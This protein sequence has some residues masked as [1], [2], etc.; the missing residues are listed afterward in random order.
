MVERPTRH[1][2]EPARAFG[3]EPDAHDSAVVGVV[4]ATDETRRFGAV[5]QL[6]R[7]VVTQEKL[8]GDITDGRVVGSG[9]PSHREQQLMLHRRHPELRRLVLAPAQEPAQRRAEGQQALVVT[10]RRRRRAWHRYI[11]PRY[12]F[13]VNRREL[14]L[15]GLAVLLGLAGG[16]AAWVLVHLIGLLTNLALLHR[17]A[18]KMPT[19][20]HYHPDWSLVVV[21]VAGAGVV[22]LLARWSPIIRGHGIPEAMEAV[23]TRE[24]RVSPRT[25]VA[26]PVSAAVAIGT[27][28]P[29]G[30]EGPIIVTGGALGSLIGQLIRVSA[31]ERKI[32]LACGAAAG[33]S[34]TFGAPIAAVILAVELLLFEFSI[35][36]VMPLVIASSVAAAMHALLFSAGPIFHVPPHKF[37]ALDHLPVFILLGV[38]CGIAAAV[39]CRGLFKIEE[40]YRRLPISPAW[41]PLI[42]AVGFASI[43]LLEP[44]VLGVGYDDINTVLAAKLAIGTLAVVL[45]AKLAAWWV[46]LGSGTSGGTL[47]PLLLIGAALGGSLSGVFSHLTN[48]S[49][50]ALAVVAMAATFGAAARAPFTSMVFAFELTRDYRSIVPIMLATAIA[51]AVARRLVDHGLMTERLARR[52]LAVP[53]DY[54]PDIFRHT[55]VSSVMS[56]A[57]A[58][59]QDAPLDEVRVLAAQQSHAWYPVVDEDNAVTGV[60]ARDRALGEDDGHPRVKDCMDPVFS[61]VPPTATLE[62]VLVRIVD[63]EAD[64]VTVVD[65]SGHLA[66]VCTRTDLLSARARQRDHEALAPAPTRRWTSIRLGRHAVERATPSPGGRADEHTTNT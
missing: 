33:M 25:A 37:E 15:G 36:A 11:V 23:L 34:A 65:S 6:D 50:S 61:S 35:R 12:N 40:L 63:E 46:A 51:D 48:P 30:A 64:L 49:T 56:T 3:G 24:S 41:H 19:L 58:V 16:G 27:G 38:V 26:K 53:R 44:R 32:L 54:L 5:H 55:P 10:I 9:M 52:G 39:I 42:G 7:T 62:D 47:A 8:V 17:W 21:A 22:S 31:N 1:H 28:G 29:F 2:A 4:L 14:L 43:G 66:G 60:I 57:V 18:W 20:A 45:V 59:P 13:A